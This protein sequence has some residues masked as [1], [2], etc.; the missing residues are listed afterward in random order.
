MGEN[1]ICQAISFILMGKG[2]IMEQ[3]KILVVEDEM[4]IAADISMTLEEHNYDVIGMAPRGETALE[5]VKENA[6]DMVLMD[7]NL[8]G[9]LDGIE[10]ALLMQEIRPTPIIFLTANV[11]QASFER[12]KAVQPYAFL[13]KPFKATELIRAIELAISRLGSERDMNPENTE[14]PDS[15]EDGLALLGDRI[16]VRF[17]DRLV[18]VSITDIIYATAE[19]NYCRIVTAERDHMLAITLKAFEERLSAPQFMRIH[20][21]HLVNLEKLDEVGEVYLR[22]GKHQ[23]PYSKS[24][25]EELYRRLRTV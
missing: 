21:S 18:K 23:V 4:I 1:P 8:K 16:F 9:K 24:Y 25:K 19:S 5:I 13:G 15:P 6:P 2:K 12:A 14:K 10:T 17:K 3:I 20:R 11:D 7:I 22:L